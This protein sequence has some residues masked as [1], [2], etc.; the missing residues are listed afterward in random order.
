MTELNDLRMAVLKGDP[1]QALLRAT[2]GKMLQKMRS[3]EDDPARVRC[4]CCEQTMDI[5]DAGKQFFGEFKGALVCAKCGESKP[6]GS[7][8]ALTNYFS[9]GFPLCC[10][11]TMTWK[12][13]FELESELP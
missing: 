7:A 2:T 10:G 3:L 5:H 12:T 4:F 11:E 6:L 9:A 8:E 1:R 13:Q